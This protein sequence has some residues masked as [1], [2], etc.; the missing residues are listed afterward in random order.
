[1][2]TGLS[3]RVVW[4]IHDEAMRDAEAMERAWVEWPAFAE[5]RQVTVV[6][7]PLI[8]VKPV[9]IEHQEAL[10]AT[11]VVVCEAPVIKR[12]NPSSRTK[13]SAA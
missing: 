5:A 9:V 11:R 2:N 7:Q 10:Q 8:S 4:P 12:V 6:G 13:E 3:L 1:M